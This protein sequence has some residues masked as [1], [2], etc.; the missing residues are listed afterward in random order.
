MRKI[1]NLGLNYNAAAMLSIENSGEGKALDY[2]FSKLPSDQ[3]LT[4]F[5]VGA[6][7]GEYIEAFIKR[8]SLAYQVSAFEPT[9]A[10]LAILRRKE[11]RSS[12]TDFLNLKEKHQSILLMQETMPP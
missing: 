3:Q 1:S 9:S 6:S 12:L 2:I 4:L 8:C 5:D 11:L 10:S 7:V